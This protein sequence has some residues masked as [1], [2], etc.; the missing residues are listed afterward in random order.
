MMKMQSSKSRLRWWD[1]FFSPKNSNSKWLQ[2]NLE[3]MNQNVRGMLKL[4]EDSDVDSFA[5]KVELYYQR[6]QQLINLVEKC[7]RIH[8]SLAE[9]Y[10]SDL[11]RSQGRGISISNVSS[12]KSSTVPPPPGSTQEP[13]GLGVLDISS[14]MP[15]S[16]ISP[17]PPPLTKFPSSKQLNVHLK[18]ELND[19]QSQGYNKPT[20]IPTPPP[21]PTPSWGSK[22][23]KRPVSVK[24]SNYH[25]SGKIPAPLPRTR[26]A[27]GRSVRMF[28][29]KYTELK[30]GSEDSF[31]SDYS[32]TQT[33]DE[34][35]AELRDMIEK[36]Y[37]EL[38]EDRFVSKLQGGIL[39]YED[40]ACDI[41]GECKEVRESMSS[42]V[43]KVLLEENLEL[44]GE[45]NRLLKEMSY[46]EEYYNEE[47]N[48]HCRSL[49]EALR[50]ATAERIEAETLL[51]SEIEKLKAIIVKKNNN[52]E[53]LNEILEAV[54]LNYE[55]VVAER[56]ELKAR[57][58]M[59]A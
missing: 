48:K 24:R 27:P 2:E 37:L 18:G 3:E 39:R 31:I 54:N 14:L 12:G 53:E 5:K 22:Q 43:D 59:L 29:T 26:P 1:G 13:R 30:H 8:C 16:T 56:D 51:A 23:L 35:E 4:I 33:D 21:L 58:A 50:Q 42:N 36:L 19:L 44:Q 28:S 25:Y 20:N 49:E 34:L 46:V 32:D 6:R 52:M 45:I 10:N 17:S 38:E 55:M 47:R 15:C 41:D 57:V 9:R 11:I 40:D 7:Y